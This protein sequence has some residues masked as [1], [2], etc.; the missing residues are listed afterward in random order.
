[1]AARGEAGSI[2]TMIMIMVVVGCGLCQVMARIGKKIR[3]IWEGRELLSFFEKTQECN[4]IYRKSRKI[5]PGV[6]SGT[7]TSK[8][9]S[10]NFILANIILPQQEVRIQGRRR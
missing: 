3:K 6:K 10:R 7:T 1:M 5:V 8:H 4:D 9:I 2:P